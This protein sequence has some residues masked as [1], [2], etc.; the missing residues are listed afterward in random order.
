MQAIIIVSG[1]GKYATGIKSS[2]EL[3]AGINESINFI[4]FTVEDSD[5]TLKEKFNKIINKNMNTS[6]LFFCDILGGT[7]F[8]TAALIANNKDNMEV[9][10]GC[11]LGSLIEAS[12]QIDNMSIKE[13]AE[14]TVNSSINSTCLFKKVKTTEIK[15]IEV[16]D[17][18]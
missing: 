14:A 9:I 7:P 16:A 4:D 13:L 12:F 8:K 5:E 3:L 2:F 11:N 6:V 15:H 18:I 1:H 10:A 17:G